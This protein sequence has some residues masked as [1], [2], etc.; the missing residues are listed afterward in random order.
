MSRDEKSVV[1]GMAAGAASG[2]VASWLMLRFIE[3]PGARLLDRWKTGE[4][5][6]KD[7]E[8]DA[9]RA[10]SGYSLEP[11]TMQASD[12]FA[13]SAPGG[14]HLSRGEREKAGTLVHYGFGTLM[15]VAYG[16]AAEY[17]PLPGLGVGSAFGT[18][19]WAGTDLLSVPAVG[20]A[21]W[22]RDEPPAAHLTHW[23]AH[24]VFGMGME[25]TRRLL[26]GR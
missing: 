11:V 23:L 7:A 13:R 19:L 26:R 25:A 2:L 21:K 3:G 24:L 6:Q 9:V 10:E 8:A 16:V 5:R 15:G 14:H 20:F 22:P 4:D 17:S 12:V 18:A 1:A